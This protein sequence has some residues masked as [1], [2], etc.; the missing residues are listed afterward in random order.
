[1]TQKYHQ[2]M[3]LHMIGSYKLTIIQ[4]VGLDNLYSVV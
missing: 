2:V 4:L 1:M 3:K